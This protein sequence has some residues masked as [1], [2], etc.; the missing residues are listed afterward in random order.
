M[1][2]LVIFVYYSRIAT[3]EG[4]VCASGNVL[5]DWSCLDVSVNTQTLVD[6]CFFHC[7][8]TFQRQLVLDTLYIPTRR[9]ARKSHDYSSNFSCFKYY[10]GVRIYGPI[11]AMGFL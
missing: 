1:F 3:K 2:S 4:I 5:N 10:C 11:C 8:S 7:V 6:V 9:L